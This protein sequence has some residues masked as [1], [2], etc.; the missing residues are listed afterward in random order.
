MSVGTVLPADKNYHIILSRK[1]LK[2]GFTAGD[3]A[4]D[5]VIDLQ[6]NVRVL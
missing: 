6:E 2:S 3:L 1:G 5:S 4:A